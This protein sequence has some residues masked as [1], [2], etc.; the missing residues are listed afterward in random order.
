MAR[1]GTPITIFGIN[2]QNLASALKNLGIPYSCE[3]QINDRY[4]SVEGYIR[5]RYSDL[6]EAELVGLCQKAAQGKIE[7]ENNLAKHL[8]IALNV[9]LNSNMCVANERERMALRKLSYAKDFITELAAN[10]KTHD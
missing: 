9:Y 1:K 6:S 2:F 10:L 4:G 8:Q 7:V 3:G 5:R